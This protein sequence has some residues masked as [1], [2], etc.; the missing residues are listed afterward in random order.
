[1]VAVREAATGRC[2]LV[3]V[4]LPGQVA[5]V[6]RAVQLAGIDAGEG[7]GGSSLS[8]HLTTHRPRAALLALLRP[9]VLVVAEELLREGPLALPEARRGQRARLVVVPAA[10]GT[11]GAVGSG[12]LGRSPQLDVPALAVAVRAA[13]TVAA[14]QRWGLGYLDAAR[15]AG[16]G[17]PGPMG[18]ADGELLLRRLRTVL[19]HASGPVTEQVAEAA[20]LARGAAARHGLP[21]LEQ[22]AV[23]EAAA[24][25]AC[26]L[27]ADPVVDPRGHPVAHLVRAAALL[28]V[29]ELV[30]VV[31][32]L[33]ELG[34]HE[35]ATAALP[36]G[37]PDH[38]GL[39]HLPVHAALVLDAVRTVRTAWAAAGYDLA[40]RPE[41]PV[42][43]HLLDTLA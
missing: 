39:E 35:A 33:G 15:A 42:L 43:P 30:P 19:H 34:L 22:Q 27:L 21:A 4:V 5:D 18:P 25:V 32:A 2:R 24:L 23:Q 12:G 26:A 6:R 10:A 37:A 8:A 9:H 11:G 17:A 29:G 20:R 14:L 38:G 31:A 3:A 40:G 7:A 41:P 13:A 16:L 1:M 28:S 36:G